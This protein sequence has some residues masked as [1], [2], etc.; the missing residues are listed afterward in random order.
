VTDVGGDGAFPEYGRFSTV[1]LFGF[2]EVV[3][4]GGVFREI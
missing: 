3:S 1:D 4:G 2:E